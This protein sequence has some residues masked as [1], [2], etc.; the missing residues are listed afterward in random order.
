M[1]KFL[2]TLLI[3][4][5]AAGAAFMFGWVQFSVPP[6]KY[7]II[8]SK[9]HG[10]DLKPV[11]S[12]EFRWIWYKLIPTNVKISVFS[13][14]QK[15][16]PIN[17]SSSL[18]SGDTYA[19]F[20]GLVNADFSWNLQ[21]EMSFTLDPH[22][23]V[24]I[25]DQNNVASQEELDIYLENTAQNIEILL[26]RLLS[27]SGSDSSRLELVMSG[28]PDPQLEKEINVNFPE[29]TDFS[30]IIYN[31][32]YPDFVLYRQIR[33][34]YEDFLKSQREYITSSFGKR[35]QTHIE[36]QLRFEELER[37]GDMLTRYPILLDYIRME[38]ENGAQ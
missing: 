35:A 12:G 38:N 28:S 25:A 7:G 15:K 17:F 6:G 26:L 10:L 23:L 37:Y 1:R 14:D 33:Q 18:P 13:I 16:Y 24:P 31:A 34:I 27:S 8:S 19:S 5:I 36:T 3:L 22:M 20:V 29:I 2:L 9:T 21:G 32:K 4:I 30:L 11:R